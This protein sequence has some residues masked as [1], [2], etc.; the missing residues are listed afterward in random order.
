MSNSSGNK[1]K[2]GRNDKPEDVEND[3][4]FGLDMDFEDALER[5]LGV[6]EDEL[7]DEKSDKKHPKSRYL[8]K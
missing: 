2:K 7:E 1:P 8:N 3:D 6:C 4:V 5:F